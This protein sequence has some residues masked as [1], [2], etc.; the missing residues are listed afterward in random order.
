MA[1]YQFKNTV[2]IVPRGQKPKVFANGS[3]HV[4]EDHELLKHP[5]FKKFLAAGMIVPYVAK[6]PQVLKPLPKNQ[7]PPRPGQLNGVG[8]VLKANAD[9]KAA[10]AATKVSPEMEVG[11]D[12]SEDTEVLPESELSKSEASE[13]SVESEEESDD[14]P[15][16]GKGKK[17]RRK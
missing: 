16:K 4:I 11:S 13:E 17:G 1:K 6:Q 15:S 8:G 2:R 14:A 9:K 7:R 3:V 5:H 12:E 10:E